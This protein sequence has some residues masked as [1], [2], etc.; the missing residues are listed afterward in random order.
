MADVWNKYIFDTN[1]ITSYE[2][3]Y[4]FTVLKRLM[5]Q[6]RFLPYSF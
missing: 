2:P 3:Q 5:S 6:E 4:A 1:V